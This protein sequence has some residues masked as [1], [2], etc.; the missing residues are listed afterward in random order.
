MREHR[1]V[2]ADKLNIEN[3]LCKYLEKH[4]KGAS[5]TISSKKL[6]VVFSVTGAEIRRTVNALRCAC[7]PI[8]SNTTGYY[9]GETQKEVM[10]TV[11]Q[12]NG[13]VQKITMARDG[14]ISSIERLED[15]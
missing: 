12:L 11:G 10:A 2:A 6:E 15:S 14:L 13:R 8:C 3:A 7:Q 1:G 4:H 9:F 5:K